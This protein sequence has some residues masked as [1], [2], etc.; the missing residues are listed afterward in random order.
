MKREQQ[1]SQGC[2]MQPGA[3]GG[4]SWRFRFELLVEY[5]YGR[6]PEMSNQS[7]DLISS[8]SPALDDINAQT[9]SSLRPSYTRSYFTTAHIQWQP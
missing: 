6:Y 7:S 1:V 3:G 8:D 5:E 4:D 9:P 2:L